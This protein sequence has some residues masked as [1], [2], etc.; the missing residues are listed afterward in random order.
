MQRVILAVLA[1][2]AFAT[3]VAGQQ[4]RWELG[5]RFHATAFRGVSEGVGT[6]ITAIRPSAGNAFGFE[7]SRRFGS[8]DA[9]LVTDY[10]GSSFEAVAPDVTVRTPGSAFD[11]ARLGFVLARTAARLGSLE[12]RIGI[13]PMLDWWAAG[14]GSDR[15]V[16]GG[17][18]QLGLRLRAGR[19]TLQ[20]GVA[21]GASA[22]PVAADELPDGFE[23][24][25][26]RSIAFM[27]QL[28][29]GL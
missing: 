16:I 18:V 29:F 4:S 15:A 14:G 7:L 12:A 13:G 28:R 5:L 19:M 24:R 1:L 20:N 3:P 2:T 11:R 23:S 26:L 9:A 6:A 27:A 10:L 17:E 21:F 25:G 8:W 22:S